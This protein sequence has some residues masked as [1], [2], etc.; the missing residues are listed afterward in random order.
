MLASLARARGWRAR[1]PPPR[2]ARASGSPGRARRPTASTAGRHR[3]PRPLRRGRRDPRSQRPAAAARAGARAAGCRG[4]RAPARASGSRARCGGRS[5]RAAPPGSG[6]VPSCSIEFSVAISRNG[7]GS[8]L[9]V[10]STVTW[11]SAMPSSSADCAFG[12]ARLIS[13]TSRTLAKIGPGRNS[14]RRSC[15]SQT[16]RPVTS[17]G[18]R[19]GVHWIRDTV[20]PST[21]PASARA[22]TVFAVPGTSSRSTWPSQAS[23]ARTRRDLLVLA[24]HDRTRCCRAACG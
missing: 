21:E 6:N 4:S 19:S 1:R 13:S 15:G 9:L 24:L 22:R 7:L 14:N 5:G 2:P 12:S 17:V 23:A 8:G 11:R 10:P 16:E 3:P 18:C 20:A